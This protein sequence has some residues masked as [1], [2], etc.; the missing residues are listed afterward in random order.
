MLIYEVFSTGSKTGFIEVIKNA[1]TLFKIQMGGGIK[2]TYQMDRS[3]L[4]RWI[5]EKNPNK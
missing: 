5:C 3:R 4:Y 2:S 1:M